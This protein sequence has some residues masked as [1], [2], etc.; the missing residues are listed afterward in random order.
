MKKALLFIAIVSSLAACKKEKTTTNA[1]VFGKWELRAIQGSLPTPLLKNPGNGDIYR[2]NSDSTYVRY[3]DNKVQSQGK[4][5]IK[6]TEVRDTIK[7][8]SIN[9]TNPAY[10]DAWSQTPNTIAIGTSALDGPTY[11]YRRI[12]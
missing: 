11:I 3:I 5:S 4:F 7:F 10:Q 1:N 2:F 12:N 9:L 6:I 8:G